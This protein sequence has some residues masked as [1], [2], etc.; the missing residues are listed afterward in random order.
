MLRSGNWISRV[1]TLA[2]G[3]VFFDELFSLLAERG[4]GIYPI[5]H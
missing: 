5:A 3:R 1:T 2:K 4:N